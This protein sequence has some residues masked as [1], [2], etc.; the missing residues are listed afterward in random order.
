MPVEDV[1]LMLNTGMLAAPSGVKAG[2]PVV[3][4]AL[5]A[6]PEVANNALATARATPLGQAIEAPIAARAAKIQEANVAKSYQNAPIIDAAQAANRTGLAVNPAITNPTISNKAK[7]MVVGQAFDEA[8]A[9][10]NAARTTELVRKDLGVSADK[11]LDATAIETALD[12]ASKPYDVV[13][14]M[15]SLSTPE[16][17]ID[18]LRA[19]KKQST[20]GGEAKTS[21]INSLVDDALQKLQKTTTGA[22]SGVG[23]GPVQVGRSGAM[24][25]NDIRSMRRDAQAV[26]KAQSVNPDPLAIAKADTQMAIA[27]ILEDVIDK[28]APNSKVLSEMQAARTRMAQIYD[29]DRAINYANETVDPQVYA[30]LLQERKGNMTGVGADIG[31][32][33]ATFP[34]IMSTQTPSASAAPTVARSGLGAATGA[35]VGGAIGGYP[36]AIAGAS[37][38]GSLGWVG[39][40]S[41]AKNMTKPEYQA[42]RALPKDYRKNA[43]SQKSQNALVP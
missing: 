1:R 2:M 43:L 18:A 16:E 25:L 27:N 15:D 11:P 34:E 26:Y 6:V 32:V 33:A 4:N 20:I 14:N 39:T 40:R 7:G 22:F 28:N 31:K 41:S 29:H 21:A 10:A 24:V 42:N 3:K 9:K 30:K 5:A 12:K 36:G 17:S 13:R 38:G 8:A 19:L 35:L 23:G 37:A